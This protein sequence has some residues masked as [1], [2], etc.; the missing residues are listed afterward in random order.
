MA[1]VFLTSAT[2]YIGQAVAQ[3]LKDKGYTIT[4]VARSEESAKQLEKQGIKAVRGDISNPESFAEEAKKADIVIHTAALRDAN[5]A[6]TDL[7][8]TRTLLKALHGTNKTFIYTSGTWVLGDT[9]IGAADE[10]T[11]TNAPEPAKFRPDL[12]EEVVAAANSGI[13]TIVIRPSIVYGNRGGFIAQILEAGR[14]DGVVRYV[15]AGENAW[16]LVHINDVASAYALAVEK[17]KAGAIYHAVSSS[18]KLKDIAHAIATALGIPGKVESIP[19]DEARKVYGPLVDGLLLNQNVKSTRSHQ[20]LG[21][22]PKKVDPKQEIVAE[23]KVLAGTAN[24]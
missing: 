23:E 14:K 24:K 4:A 11:Q 16:A 3:A 22:Q 13:R 12:E 21:W 15:G 20:E 1:N 6:K 9:G 18:V 8:T 17:G 5:F 10:S 7:E 19:V 2:G